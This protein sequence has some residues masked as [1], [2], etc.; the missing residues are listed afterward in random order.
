MTMNQSEIDWFEEM[1]KNL[2][3]VVRKHGFMVG[4][5]QNR[6]G[7]FADFI[8]NIDEAN[9]MGLKLNPALAVKPFKLFPYDKDMGLDD[10]DE[11]LEGYAM[12]RENL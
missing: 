1:H 9:M 4:V 2:R 5:T 10:I 11:F 12:A 7:E 3:K 8:I 6:G